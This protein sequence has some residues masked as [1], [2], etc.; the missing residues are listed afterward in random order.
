MNDEF[1]QLY[2]YFM[3]PLGKQWELFPKQPPEW[4]WV[5]L[6]MVDISKKFYFCYRDF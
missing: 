1:L 4:M 2:E 3:F 6:R 5:F